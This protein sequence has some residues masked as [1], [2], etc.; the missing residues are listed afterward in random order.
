MGNK[1]ETFAY[2]TMYRLI[3]D[4]GKHVFRCIIRSFNSLQNSGSL[5][6]FFQMQSISVNSVTIDILYIYLFVHLASVF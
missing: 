1:V 4:K 3:L 2:S 6:C 5:E